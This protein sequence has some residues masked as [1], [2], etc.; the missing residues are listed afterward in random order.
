MIL[1]PAP[2]RWP[3]YLILVIVFVLWANSFIAV[4]L[5]V[6]EEVP[7]AQ[8][9]DAVDFV[10]VRFAP[11]ALFCCLWFLAFRRERREALDLLRHHG[12]GVVALA[13][14]NVWGYNL[15][16][17]AG[18]QRVA[19]GTGALII[20]L[21]PILTFF[22]AAAFGF[23]QA[24]W[25]KALGLLL[26]FAGI[27]WVV[28]HGGHRSVEKAYLLDAL[29]LLGAPISWAIYT[30]FS[31][32]LLGRWSPGTVNLVILGLGSLPTLPLIFL[33][34]SFRPRLAAWGAEQFG[35]AVFLSLGCTLLAFWLWLVALK[36]LPAT[37]AAAFVFLNPP[38]T[39][40]FE[41]L[42]FGRVP[43]S[44]LLVG[45]AVVLLGVFLAVRRGRSEVAAGGRASD[46]KRAGVQ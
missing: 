34:S 12:F 42:W 40:C 31:R 13:F 6:G 14:F 37:T 28:V 8:R 43:S 18:H 46:W 45:G 38:L 20:V 29:L 5:L 19:A 44:G 22:L 17:G 39:L 27:Y 9:L 36:R 41:W 21:N 25:R 11:V 30:V 26:A 24:T 7:A 10:T 16:F 33:R 1:P 3:A 32:P 2:R 23:E 4:R 15:A 35:A